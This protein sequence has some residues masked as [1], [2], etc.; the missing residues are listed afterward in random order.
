MAVQPWELVEREP[1]AELKLV[2]T[3]PAPPRG[4]PGLAA[5]FVLFVALAVGTPSI[6]AA[7]QADPVPQRWVPRPRPAT[8]ISKLDAL[9]PIPKG[10]RPSSGEPVAGMFFVRCTRLWSAHPDGSHARKIL[11]M[12]GISSPTIAPNART[13]AFFVINETGQELWMAGADGSDPTRVGRLTSEGSEV[14]PLATALTWSPQGDKLAF[15]LVDGRYA[16]FEGG[17]AVW[18]LRLKDGRFIREGTGWPAPFWTRDKVAFATMQ[19]SNHV[20]FESPYRGRHNW[21]LRSARTSYRDL[22][23]AMVPV[24]YS[25]NTKHGIAVL[26]S[27]AGGPKLVVKDLY[28]RARTVFEPPLGYEFG[29]HARP[30]ISQDGGA[31]AIDLVD[32][33]GERDLGVL[34]P[35]TGR[36]TVLDYA[37]DAT[38]SPAP[39]V[40]GPLGAR[41]AV[42][43]ATDLLNSWNSG[44]T[45]RNLLVDKSDRGYFTSDRWG[46]GYILGAATRTGQSWSVPATVYVT[47]NGIQQWL[48]ADIEVAATNGRVAADVVNATEPQPLTS[49]AAAV[50][51]SETALGR[52]VVA[53]AV[54]PGSKFRRM[55]L[56]AWTYN[57][58]QQIAFSAKVPFETA[59][60]TKMKNM[61]FGYG[62]DL[63]FSLGCGGE[64]DPQ[65]IDLGGTPAL[66]DKSGDTDQ[67]IWPS[68]LDARTG[69]Y[70]VHG[71]D[72]RKEEVIDVARQMAVSSP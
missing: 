23:A 59:A 7:L 64:V 72:M 10:A 67:V 22:A 31:V 18:T 6:A 62:D 12:P 54:P 58:S 55:S 20:R 35:A 53:P 37:W 9:G 25:D 15:A 32:D 1:R 61:G 40:T 39:A 52:D 44:G 28:R 56:Y 29:Q 16:E 46:A 34:A 68:T 69:T 65:E 49:L 47:R 57:G 24:G 27:P 41:R 66:V 33:S 4:R 70:S 14:L 43:V 63:D 30:S 36:W 51:F 11:E 13:V 5:L 2:T 19:D 48:R 17:S 3:A 26:R 71:Y 8:E 38:S 42:T 60:G 45:K 21:L 50:A